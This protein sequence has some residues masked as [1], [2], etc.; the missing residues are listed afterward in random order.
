[1]MKSRLWTAL[2]LVALFTLPLGD[3]A[4]VKKLS[5]EES[6][7]VLNVHVVAHT[8]DDVGWRKTVEQYYY[9][10]NKTIDTRGNVKSII[11][12]AI[13]SLLE[14]PARTFTYVE[15]KFFSMWW[16]EQTDAIKD[17]VRFLLANQQLFFVNGGWC[18][19]DEAST[20]YTSMIDQTT[21]GH[22][23]LLKELGVVPTIGWQLDPFGHSATQASL[24]SAKVGFDALYFGR[25]DYQ[26]LELRRRTRE[27]EGLWNAS[28]N[29]NDTTIFWGLT[30]SY[31][32]NYGPPPGF[33]FD[34]WCEDEPLIGANS[35]RLM[36]R[37]HTFLEYLRIQSDETQGNHI[38]LTMGSDFNVSARTEGYSTFTLNHY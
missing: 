12:T 35:T 32:G 34:I 26:D 11:T 1:M 17:S 38:M 20:H 13:E 8:H 16:K 24:L 3:S 10:W 31:R 36:E 6:E 15:Q 9:G 30:G 18:M 29:L 22:Q 5:A 4:L 14:N 19:H 25:V 7:R 23:F 21:L 33:C 2:V 27:C 37:I 28:D